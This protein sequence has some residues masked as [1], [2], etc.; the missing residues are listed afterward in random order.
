VILGLIVVD[1]MARFQDARH[2]TE[3]ESNAL[4]DVVLLSN[5]WPDEK[6]AQIRTLALA[7]IDRV[8]KDEWPILDYGQV[9]PSARRAALDLID[10]VSSFEPQSAKDTELYAAAV[11]ACCEFWNS[12]RTRTNTAEHGVPFLEWVVI[13]VGGVITVAFTYFFKVEHLQIQVLM[14]AMVAIIIALCI[15]LVLMFGY[16]FSGEL[17]VDP[18]CFKVTQAIINYQSGRSAMPVP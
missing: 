6:R 11:A 8:L 10:A 3:Q 9:A 2:T 1:A 17:K 13:L 12:R 7:Y 14:T 16:P 5:H 15:F 18:S 4:A